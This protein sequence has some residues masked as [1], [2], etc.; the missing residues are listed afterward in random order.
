M[1]NN[2]I[3]IETFFT[4][5]TLFMKGILKFFGAAGENPKLAVVLVLILLKPFIVCI[6]KAPKFGV[7]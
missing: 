2:V 4:L 7:Q 5:V 3:V 1:L 6:R